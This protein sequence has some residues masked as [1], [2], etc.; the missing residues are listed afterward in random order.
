[1]QCGWD[2]RVFWSP[3]LTDSSKVL[4]NCTFSSSQIFRDHFS[5]VS[6]M[7]QISVERGKRCFLRRQEWKAQARII[8]S[9]ADFSFHHYNSPPLQSKLPCELLYLVYI[10]LLIHYTILVVHVY[11]SVHGYRSFVRRKT[12]LLSFL[13]S[14]RNKILK[15]LPQI[16]LFF[17]F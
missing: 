2:P 15:K 14:E 7:I 12:I 5:C 8:C 3:I 9:Q 1:M 16:S 17:I 6:S 11:L 4:R 10:C 13:F